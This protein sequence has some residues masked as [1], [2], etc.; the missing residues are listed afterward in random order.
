[1]IKYKAHHIERSNSVLYVRNSIQRENRNTDKYRL[2]PPSIY[3]ATL[4][5]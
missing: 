5:P 2:A 3:Y 4:T 1:M